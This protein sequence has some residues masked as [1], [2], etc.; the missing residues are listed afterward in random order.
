M[1]LLSGECHKTWLKRSQ[2]WFRQWLGAIR[3]QAI[4]WASKLCRHMASLGHN[5]L[6]HWGRVMHICSHNL[7]ISSSD[8]GLSPG[9]CQTI[10]CSN[11]LI[12]SVGLLGTKFSEILIK[13][14]IFSL[15]MHLK[16]AAGNWW[17]FC[18]GLNVLKCTTTTF[19][20]FAQ[21]HDDINVW[22]PLLA[23][24]ESNPPVTSGFPSQRGSNLE[25]WCSL[26]C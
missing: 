4:S 14:Y 23:L 2:Q 11:S 9:W 16:I 26:W 3:Q 8:N 5:E 17:P 18:L 1:K 10:I 25:L 13:I 22:T 20:C 21:L 6:T 15:K 12:L 24:C 7:S 19:H